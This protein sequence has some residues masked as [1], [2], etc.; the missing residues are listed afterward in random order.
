MSRTLIKNATV[1]TMD[2]AD[3]TGD[4][5]IADGKIAE[6]GP[7]LAAEGAEVIDASGMIAMPGF[8]NAHIHT[9]QAG[10]RGLAADW[11]LF[12]YFKGMH[13][14]LATCFRPEDMEIANQ[15]GMLHQL[16]SG[17]TTIADWCH[18]NHTPD[19]TDAAIAGLHA[20]GGRAKFLHGSPKPDPKPGEPHFS[21]VPMPRSEIERLRTGTLASDDALVTMGMAILGPQMSV[22]TVVRTDFALAREMDLVTSMHV[23]GNM[24]WGNAWAELEQAGLLGRHINIVHGN[25]LPDDEVKRLLDNGAMVNV[26]AEIELQMGFG[27]PL[28]RIV[29]QH[30]DDQLSIGS[31]VES[32]VAGDMFNVTR[33][34]LQSARHHHTRIVRAETGAPPEVIGFTTRQALNWATMGGARMLRMEDRIG[35]L[36]VGKEADIVLL[37]TRSMNMRPVHDPVATIVFHARPENVDTVMVGGRIVKRDGKMLGVDLEALTDRLQASGRRVVE[38]FRGKQAGH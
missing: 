26:T 19:H 4:I 23:S 8:V 24:L 9:W 30:A 35:S 1:V 11:T 29:S 27:E 34:T 33:I 12:D 3:Y 2:G 21:E 6:L 10:L 25:G 13:A 28:T 37:E 15:V 16:S 22:E 32:G 7:D 36:T 38:E 18:A 31:D 20:A 14:G 5:L 17:A